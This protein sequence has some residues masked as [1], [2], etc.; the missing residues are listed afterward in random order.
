MPGAVPYTSTLA[1][2]NVTL[3]YVLKLA[4]LGYEV[5]CAKNPELAKGLNIVEGEIVYEEIRDFFESV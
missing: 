1:L 3:P 5:A 2:T 4:N